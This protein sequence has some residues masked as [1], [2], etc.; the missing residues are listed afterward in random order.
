MLTEVEPEKFWIKCAK[1]I[2]AA[3]GFEMINKVPERLAYAQMWPP[4]F[5]FGT[6][7]FGDIVINNEKDV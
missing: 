4:H 3:D 5:T 1:K 2:S 7:E 6:P